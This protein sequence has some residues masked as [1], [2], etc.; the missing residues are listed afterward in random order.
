MDGPTIRDGLRRR[1]RWALILLL[2][3]WLAFAFTIVPTAGQAP[4]LAI[5]PGIAFSLYLPWFFHTLSS[6]P[7]QP[8]RAERRL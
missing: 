4:V 1:K 3:A 6:L 7:R 2:G 5:I 8:W